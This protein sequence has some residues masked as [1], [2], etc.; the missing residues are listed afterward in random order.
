MSCRSRRPARR[1]AAR[2]STAVAASTNGSYCE[3]AQSPPSAPAVSEHVG[4]QKIGDAHPAFRRERRSPARGRSASAW[5]VLP[6]PTGRSRPVPGSGS[7]ASGGTLIVGAGD[8]RWLRRRA[9]LDDRLGENRE[10][11][12]GV[13]HHQRGQRNLRAQRGAARA[14]NP[15]GLAVGE[16]RRR[17]CGRRR[18]RSPPCT[19]QNA[20]R[21]WRCR[22]DS[23]RCRRDSSRSRTDPTAAE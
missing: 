17:R 21:R 11:D 5:R 9:P 19:R 18:S 8:R 16:D 10:A 22:P 20:R 2:A 15:H 1:P 3:A 13:D 14:E 12:E 4:V 7:T 23:R 6:A